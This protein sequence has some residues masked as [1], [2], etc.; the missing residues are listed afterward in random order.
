M[1]VPDSAVLHQCSP[2]RQAAVLLTWVFGPLGLTPTALIVSTSFHQ[3]WPYKGPCW[4][5]CLGY[6]PRI[7]KAVVERRFYRWGI[8]GVAI[9]W[10]RCWGLRGWYW[11][12]RTANG[13]G[14]WRSHFGESFPLLY[15]VEGIKTRRQQL[16]WLYLNDNQ[17]RS[18]NRSDLELSK[19]VWSSNSSYS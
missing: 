14:F 9:A 1:V 3:C 18:G 6:Y 5:A 16:H 4:L 12:A 17:F 19:F 11:S 10:L 13:T 8:G 7:V 15:F 2:S